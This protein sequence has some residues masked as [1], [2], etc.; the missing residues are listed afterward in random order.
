MIKPIL[1]LLCMV[2]IPIA[3]SSQIRITEKKVEKV[4]V[5]LEE[6]PVEIIEVKTLKK[7]KALELSP[8][9]KSQMD[10]NVVRVKYTS[11]GTLK[12]ILIDRNL[13]PIRYNFLSAMK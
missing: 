6:S 11:N 8:E 9:M 10:Y 3:M 12:T 13:V 7:W 5:Q 1:I 4:I 2:F